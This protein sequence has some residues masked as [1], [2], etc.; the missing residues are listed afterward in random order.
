MKKYI[1]LWQK[2]D[3]IQTGEA[4]RITA[5]VSDT[6]HISINN[7]IDTRCY[8]TQR[9]RVCASATSAFRSVFSLAAEARHCL[10]SLCVLSSSQPGESEDRRVKGL[11][12]NI[13]RN[14][15]VGDGRRRTWPLA[16]AHSRP[17]RPASI[18]DAR[19]F[20]FL[21][22]AAVCAMI[23]ETK[24]QSLRESRKQN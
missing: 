13:C 22:G 7:K 1:Y 4:S 6:V 23:N 18:L 11:V 20:T 2:W 19:Q 9:R 12:P 5:L 3:I 24:L 15:Q 10:H 8:F 17:P 21:C 14:A 16:V